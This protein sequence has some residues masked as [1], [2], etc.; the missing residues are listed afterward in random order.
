MLPRRPSQTLLHSPEPSLESDHAV[1]SHLLVTAASGVDKGQFNPDLPHPTKGL[2]ATQADI[3]S[4]IKGEARDDIKD[5][6]KDPIKVDTKAETEAEVK[7]DSKIEAE[8]ETKAEGMNEPKVETTNDTTDTANPS[9]KD[10]RLHVL[11]VEDNLVNQKVLA[12]QLRKADLV[13]HT[14][15]NG[16]FALEHLEKTS[17][18]HSAGMP[19]S[20]ILMDC[21]MPEMDGL[22]CCRKIRDMQKGGVIKGHVPIIAV[23]ANIRGGQVSDAKESGMDDVVGK[24]YRIADLLGK[25]EELLERLGK[26]GT[27]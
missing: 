24:P 13:V 11:V 3:R 22:T 25:M 4:D 5:N 17:F 6:A 15:D 7:N 20:I 10:P 2:A 19:L 1:A 14:A 8:N 21:E 26:E 12:K 18:R 9:P 16:V 27:G 23:T